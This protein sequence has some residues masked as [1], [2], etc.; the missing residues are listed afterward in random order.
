[1]RAERINEIDYSARLK[2]PYKWSVSI[3][4]DRGTKMVVKQG[5]G[6]WTNTMY[7]AQELE[8]ILDLKTN[9]IKTKKH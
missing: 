2:P 4:G 8:Q 7:I 3:I 6:A 9:N 1:M 5:K